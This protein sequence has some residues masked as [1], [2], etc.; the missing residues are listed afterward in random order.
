[1]AVVDAAS[2]RRGVVYVREGLIR[3]G[4][5]RRHVAILF[6]REFAKNTNAVGEV[7]VQSSK[8]LLIAEWALNEPLRSSNG[9][10]TTT[11]AS[12]SWVVR[13]QE[14]KAKSL[15]LMIGPPRLTPYCFR[16]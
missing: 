4:N 16:L 11:G 8:K 9:A 12:K 5:E 10:C 1:M 3:A 7:V 2:E 15:S 13:S 6:E 14:P